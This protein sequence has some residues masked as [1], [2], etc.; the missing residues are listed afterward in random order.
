MESLSKDVLVL[1]A[2]ELNLKDLLA[3]C[4][5][6]DNVNKAVCKNDFFWS[7]KLFKDYKLKVRRGA[8]N[9][10]EEMTRRLE[11]FDK[12]ARHLTIDHPYMPNQMD[13][14][15][16]D[17]L[18]VVPDYLEKFLN[19]ELFP[20]LVYL[21]GYHD[22]IGINYREDAMFEILKPYL[23]DIPEAIFRIYLKKWSPKLKGTNLFLRRVLPEALKWS[24]LEGWWHEWDQ[25][26]IRET[27]SD[28]IQ[29]ALKEHPKNIQL[30]EVA[31]L[32]K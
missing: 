17:Y 14:G 22:S 12:A 28:E 25:R 3:F 13:L 30:Q 26:N 20:L 7:Q 2:L 9:L 19:R 8:K 32:L 27:L 18:G 1:L 15:V 16:P 5:S 10:Y 21:D 4:E 24:N 23:K 6:Y 11:R 29:E 31:K